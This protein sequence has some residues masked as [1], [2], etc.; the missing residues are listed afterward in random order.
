M[1]AALKA[2]TILVTGGTGFIGSALVRALLLGGATVRSLD[3]DSRGSRSR[4]DDVCADV[5]LRTGDIRN[6]ADVSDA[7]RSVDA[8]CHLAA[9]NGTETF[10]REPG[11]VLEVAVKGMAHVLDACRE[12][13]VPELFL[14]SSSEV[15]QTPGRVPTDETV[16]LSVPDVLNPRYSYAGGKIISELM[17]L[18]CEQTNFQRV[19]VFR[20]HNVYG[21]GMGSEHVIPQFALRMHALLDHADPI[22]FPI[23]GTGEETRAFMFISD[24]VDGVLKIIESGVHREIYHVGTEDEVRIADLVKAVGRHVGRVLDIVT[25]AAPPGGTPRRCPDTTKLKALGFSPKVDLETG[26]QHTL[27]WYLEHAKELTS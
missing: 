12:H 14:A 24:L 2:K 3:D 6:Y 1:N 26:L 4:L 16:A 19:V 23:Q 9:V 11:R 20:P 22:P 17:T 18:H 13:D 8:V 21:P 25:G 15:Y 27:S 10:Y 5:E 7:V